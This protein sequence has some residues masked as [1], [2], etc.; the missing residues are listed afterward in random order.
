MDNDLELDYK[1]SV[2]GLG[3]LGLSFSLL[4]DDQ[5]WEC[6]G[7]DLNSDRME[8]IKNRTIKTTEPTIEEFVNLK[9]SS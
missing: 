9:N 2:I 3:K 1:V 8:Q 5:A 6:Y 4:V 7:Y